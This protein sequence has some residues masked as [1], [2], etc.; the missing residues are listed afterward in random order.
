MLAP[1]VAAYFSA[2]AS[3]VAAQTGVPLWGYSLQ[4]EPTATAGWPSCKWTP[5]AARDYLRDF[6]LPVMQRDHPGMHLLVFDH[7][8]DAAF[9]WAQVLYAD[10]AVRAG[11]WGLACHWY[12]TPSLVSNL[13]LTHAAF[14]DRHILHTEACVCNAPSGGRVVL[15]GDP[16][17]FGLGEQYG[18]GLMATL[19][20]WAE[21]FTDWVGK[22]KRAGGSGS[23][24]APSPHRARPRFPVPPQNMLLDA[25]GGG[26]YHERPFSCNAPMIQQGGKLVLQT[27][28]YFMGQLSKFLVP[29]TRIV[30]AM[31]YAGTVAPQPRGAFVYQ[32]SLAAGAPFGVLAGV[33]PNGT[34]VLVV[35]NA[36]DAAVAFKLVAAPGVFANVTV[37]PH[38]FTTLSWA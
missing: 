24:S 1:A 37:P 8:Y 15:P 4:N 38:S 23:A 12:T 30:G 5:E 7:N 26:P 18:F 10:P 21:G 17:W 35:L 14:P 32:T 11:A 34:T 6:M 2:Y 31:H 22:E 29:G 16:L 3:A 9:E 27:P 36:Q 13:N 28:Y 25:P 20:N 33:A 19:Q